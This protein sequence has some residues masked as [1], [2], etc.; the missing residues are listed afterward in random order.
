MV[1]HMFTL[2]KP[3]KEGAAQVWNLTF[4]QVRL[5]LWSNGLSE[6]LLGWDGEMLYWLLKDSTDQV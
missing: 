4:L 2:N 6:L 3:D 1:H 5:G